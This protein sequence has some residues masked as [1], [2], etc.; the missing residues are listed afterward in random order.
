MPQPRIV[1]LPSPFSRASGFG[2]LVEPLVP[3]L[4]WAPGTA[5][6]SGE[7]GAGLCSIEVRVEPEMSQ[8]GT[9][10]QGDRRIRGFE[11]TKDCRRGRYLKGKSPVRSFFG[12]ESYPTE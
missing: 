9:K 3:Q 7:C 11:N 8:G 10:D 1:V 5:I 2:Q 6:G 12:A 4:G